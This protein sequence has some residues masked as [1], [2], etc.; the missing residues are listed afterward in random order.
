MKKLLIILFLLPV[1]FAVP[2]G[3]DYTLYSVPKCT[4]SIT[5]SVEASKTINAEEYN[6]KSCTKNSSTQWSCPCN[7][8]FDIIL[9]TRINTINTYS[10][11]VNYQVEEVAGSASTSSSSSGGGGGSYVLPNGTVVVNPN[12]DIKQPI[13]A[14]STDEQ[15][16]VDAQ[17]KVEINNVPII[18]QPEKADNSTTSEIALPNIAVLILLFIIVIGVIAGGGGYFVYKYIWKTEDVEGTIERRISAKKIDNIIERLSAKP[19]EIS[20]SQIDKFIG[21]AKF[22]EIENDKIDAFIRYNIR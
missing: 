21:I 20:D 6:L 2:A 8:P 4:G 17:R 18:N 16:K 13:G 9:N 3:T 15:K 12:T 11:T 7:N 14:P 10:F 19:K 22:K 1:V 5:V